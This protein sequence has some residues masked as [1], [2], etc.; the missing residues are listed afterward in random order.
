MR[1]QLLTELQSLGGQLARTRRRGDANA[2]EEIETRLLVARHRRRPSRQPPANMFL[3]Q[4]YWHQAMALVVTSARSALDVRRLPASITS[5]IHSWLSIP[6]IGLRCTPDT[7]KAAQQRVTTESR[8]GQKYRLYTT[9][10]AAGRRSKARSVLEGSVRTTTSAPVA[11]C[12]RCHEPLDST[13]HSICEIVLADQRRGA[14]GEGVV[15]AELRR[16]VERRRC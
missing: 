16:P 1:K 9:R 12:E 8:N 15:W 3:A 14:N 5:K 2:I 13:D 10:R 4:S 7:I 6:E 11:C